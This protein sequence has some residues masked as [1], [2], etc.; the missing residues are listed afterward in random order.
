VRVVMRGDH[1]FVRMEDGDS[2]E[3]WGWWGSR[4]E[5]AWQHASALRC[6]CERGARCALC[7]ERTPDPPGRHVAPPPPPQASCLQSARCPATA[8]ASRWRSS[9]W[10]TRAATSWSKWLTGRTPKSTPL[11][12]WGSGG[13]AERA[14]AAAAAVA[15]AAVGLNGGRGR[16]NSMHV[17]KTYKLAWACG[18]PASTR[19]RRRARARAS[20]PRGPRAGS[21]TTPATSPPRWMTT[22]SWCAGQRRR[23]RCARASRP[24]RRR[25]GPREAAAAAAAAARGRRT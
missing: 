18:I 11:W 13:G 19:A 10:L 23:S 24:W 15:A 20:C 25:A 16:R 8:P 9:P 21:A 17:I 12:A 3:R 1:C 14:G 4:S 22:A 5:P 2:G 7:A 6:S